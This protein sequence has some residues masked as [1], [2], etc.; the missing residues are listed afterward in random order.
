VSSGRLIS[1]GVFFGKKDHVGW[2][3]LGGGESD[4]YFLGNSIVSA[5]LAKGRRKK[6]G[7]LLKRKKIA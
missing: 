2:T 6:K 3:P 1:S 7:L 4:I 5:L